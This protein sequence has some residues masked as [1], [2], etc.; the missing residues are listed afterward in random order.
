MLKDEVKKGLVEFGIKA[1]IVDKDIGY[2]LRS[3][4][5]T[6]FDIEYTM[7]LGYAAAVYLLEGKSAD[8]ISIQD[9]KSIPISF[10]KALDPETGRTKV[11]MVDIG[12]RSYEVALEYMI[13]LKKEDF[14]DD[15]QLVWLAKAAGKTPKE[16]KKRFGYLVGIGG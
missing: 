8:M 11:R 10:A 5:P 12:T 14:T 13:R 16:F 15:K 1:T 4:E 2:E 7:D 6:P 9:G 3:V